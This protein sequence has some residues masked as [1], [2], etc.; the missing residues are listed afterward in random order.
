MLDADMT[1]H[2]IWTVFEAAVIAGNAL[3]RSR[4]HASEHEFVRPAGI[5]RIEIQGNLLAKYAVSQ[6]K[7]ALREP[8]ISVWM[9]LVRPVFAVGMACLHSP[10]HAG[11][12]PEA[13]LVCH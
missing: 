5:E 1:I 8:N 6:L 13:F 4:C 10:G 9:G 7:T 2:K 11:P 3:A 12:S